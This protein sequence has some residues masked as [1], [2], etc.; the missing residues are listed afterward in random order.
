MNFPDSWRIL[1]IEDDEDDYILAREMLSQAWDRKIQLD[2]AASYIEG[3]QKLASDEYDAVLV[4]YD[5]GLDTGIH[6]I[7]EY[8][9]DYPAPLIL[10]TGRGSREVDQEALQAGATL[11]LSK[12]E[13]NPLLLER[14]IRYAIQLKQRET[15]LRHARQRLEQEL[16][17]RKRAEIGLA[18]SE[19]KFAKAFHSSPVAMS[20]TRLRDGQYLEVNE[21]HERLTGYSRQEIIGRTTDDLHVHAQ[22][23]QREEMISRLLSQSGIRDQEFLIRRKDGTVVTILASIEP[24]DLEGEECLLLSAVDITESVNTRQQVE[25]ERARLETV[26]QTLPAGVWIVDENGRPVMTNL[27]ADRI[28]GGQDAAA[29]QTARDWQSYRAWWADTGEEISGEDWPI[30]QALRSNREFHGVEVAIERRDGSRTYTLVSASPVRSPEN[31]SLGAVA[32]MLD[33]SDQKAIRDAYQESEQRYRA[34]SEALEVERKKLAAVIEE[35]PVAV[36][37]G[38]PQGKVLSFNRIGLALHG[39]DSEADMFDHLDNYTREFELLLPGGER[40]PVEEWPASRA[41]RGEFVQNLEVILHNLKTGQKKV[42]T[43][44]ANPVRGSQG[45]IILIIYTLFDLTER[46]Q[47]EESLRTSEQRFRE[48]ADAMPQLVWTALPD[49][50]VDYYNLRHKLYKGIGVTAEGVWEW[51]P[52]LHPDDQQPTVQAWTHS[53]E[54]GEIYQIEHRVQMSDGSFRWHLSRGIPALDEN[55]VVCRW[56]GTAT[57]IHDQ[58]TAQEKL[59]ISLSRLELFLGANMIGTVLGKADGTLLEVNDYFLKLLGYTRA[60]FDAGRINWRE[61][62]PA[63]WLPADEKAVREIAETGVSTPYEKQYLRTDGQRVWVYISNAS[64]P[65]GTLAAIVLDITPRKQAEKDL[66]HYTHELERSN[67]ALQAFTSIAS[68][69]LQEPLRKVRA[70]GSMLSLRFSDQLGVEGQDYIH[71]I[72]SASERM[73]AMIEGLLSLSRVTSRGSEFVPVDLN[74]IIQEVITDLEIRIAESGGEIQVGEMPVL[75]GDPLQMRQLFQNLIGNALKYHRAGVPP[76]VVLSAVKK[77]SFC[78]I[79]V[80]DNGIG[81][82]PENFEEI[83]EPFVRMHGKVDYEGSGMGLAICRKI[84]ERHE[85]RIEVDSRP[86][87]GTTFIVLLPDQE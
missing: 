7:R 4:D 22:T 66:E 52:V 57:D 75:E 63:E 27:Q 32:V 2:W 54:T 69:D 86:G 60:D 41:L 31:Q 59:R 25:T 28:F 79:R 67:Q 30:L 17:E 9:S 38:D 37:I 19:E 36:C 83:F 8:S 24:V 1:Y 64:L 40:L 26:L 47:A 39:F 49:G 5:L 51:S 73:S 85:G 74:Q 53:V 3:Q 65:D 14:V 21:S 72:T 81:I 13:A 12:N 16:E 35:L 56:Y 44:S 23:N 55:Q 68:H 43:Y 71:R 11:Y 50:T 80:A 58:K 87:E 33:I 77:D 62:T 34:L 82:N 18:K 70:F 61:I 15:E 20:I 42:I 29:G 10:F 46:K 76:R 6:L 84:V 48:L 78:E 45:E